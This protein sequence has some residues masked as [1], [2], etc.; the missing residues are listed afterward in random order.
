MDVNCNHFVNICV[1]SK[2]FISMKVFLFVCL[3]LFFFNSKSKGDL[4]ETK[5]IPFFIHCI[6]VRLGDLLLKNLHRK[7]FNL[8][9][10]L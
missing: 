9:L 2:S 4:K 3:F 6:C 8:E 1:Y 7:D 5:I 10:L